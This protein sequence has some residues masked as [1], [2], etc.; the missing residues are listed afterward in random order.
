MM[1]ELI[2]RWQTIINVQ[3]ILQDIDSMITMETFRELGTTVMTGSLFPCQ[4]SLSAV[5]AYLN[6]DDN[7]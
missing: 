2:K 4:Q 7:I 5:K 1:T 6:K 3:I